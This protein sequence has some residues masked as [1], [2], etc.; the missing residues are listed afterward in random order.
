M[1]VPAIEKGWTL[2]LD[3]DGVINEELPGDYVRRTA[4]FRFT[5]G[6]EEAIAALSGLFSRICIVTNQRGV[7]KGLMSEADL[8][9][10]HQYMIRG[11]EQ[12]GGRIDK[13]Y[14][15]TDLDNSSENRKP[16][17][18]MA[19]AAKKDFPEIDFTRSVMIG[20]TRSDMQFGRTIGAF[21]IFIPSTQPQLADTSNPLIDAVFDHLKAAANALTGC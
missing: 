14:Y 2:F 13:I 21:T 16:Q 17:T 19:L 7:G 11:I 1:K 15:C 4:D 9:A 8:E 3:R 5:N 20:N 12:A 18:G 6:A 10:V